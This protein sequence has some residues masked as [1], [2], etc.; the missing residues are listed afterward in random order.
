MN[1]LL[2]FYFFHFII[3]YCY[4]SIV[5]I[6]VKEAGMG[7]GMYHGP[8][9]PASPPMKTAFGGIKQSLGNNLYGRYA[10]PTKNNT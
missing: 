1:K 9:L 6:S 10:K 7:H 4:L 8:R 5:N 2:L 3:H